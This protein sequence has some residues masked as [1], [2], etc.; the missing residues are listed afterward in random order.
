MHLPSS[1]TPHSATSHRLAALGLLLALSI[2]GG[3]TRGDYFVAANK[4]VTNLVD[5]KSHDPRWGLPGFNINM[6]PRSRFYDIYDHVRPPMPHDDPTAHQLMHYID[7]KR[8]WPFWAIDGSRKYLDNPYWRTALADYSDVNEEGE[9]HIDLDSALTVARVNNPDFQEQLETIYLSALDVSTERFRFD[10]QFFGGNLTRY[11][12][13]GRLRQ[14]GDADRV[15]PGE[16]NTLRTDTDFAVERR[17]ATAG[18]LAVNFANS[19]VWQFAGPDTEQAMSL[20]SFAVA[21]PLLRGAG[22]AVALEQLTLSERTL[23][24]NLRAFQRYRQGF[25]TDVAIGEEGVNGPQR[26]GGFF[27]GTGLTGFTGTGAGGFGGVGQNA[28]GRVGGNFGGGGGAAGAG[29][30]GGGAGEVGGFVGLL[31]KLQQIRN[32]QDGLRVRLEALQL[33]EAHLEAGTIDLQQV[34][35]FR[36]SI[37]TERATLL[38]AR[39]DLQTDMDSFKSGTLGLPPDTPLSLDDSLIRQF[40]FID[41][42]MSRLQNEIADFRE[43]FGE[44]NKA[45]VM[46][47]LASA[48]KRLNDLVKQ[49]RERLEGVGADLNDVTTNEE[50]IERADPTEAERL[51]QDLKRLQ[52]TY[53]ELQRR[54]A[55]VDGAIDELDQNLTQLPPAQVADSIATLATE[56]SLAVDEMTLVQARAR[57]EMVVVKPVDLNPAVAFSIARANRLDWMNNRAALVD[58]WRLIVFNANALRSDLNVFFTGDLQTNQDSP[59]RFRGPTGR[60]S[61]G[62]EF[63]GPFTRLLERNN[64]RQILIDYE[65]S[66]RQLIQY[67][68]GVYRTLRA[69]LRKLNEHHQNLEIQRRAVAI[70]IRRVDQTRE[71]LNQPPSPEEGGALGPTAALNLITALSDLRNAQD[72]FMSVWL[73]FLAA[74]MVLS[75]ELGLMQLDKRGIWI[76]FDAAIEV[77]GETTP[78]AEDIEEVPPPIP[79]ELFRALDIDNDEIGP[80]QPGIEPIA[81]PGNLPGNAPGIPPGEPANELPP[82]PLQFP[83]KP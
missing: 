29:F 1:P 43:E 12:H 32:R 55:Q 30:A 17:F 27:G 47:A 4:Q 6:N 81:P 77:Q 14:G 3:C 59:F 11:T 71:V 79:R 10:V 21:Q 46:T 16:N 51:V 62:V 61:V 66:R 2:V 23:L 13:L 22:R 20:L 63:D 7:H 80:L 15:K 56:I 68:D 37:E 44:L 48:T 75:R 60:L 72:N 36:Q 40:Q 26:R 33:L 69:V 31:Q 5:E 34:D 54:M 19:F 38:Q 74:R 45:P 58:T 78:K 39:N 65:Q 76:D 18:E 67:Q 9:L 83:A 57:L 50:A 28:F 8:G 82:P 35:Q 42:S 73:N 25:Y 24:A 52:E 70:A 64:F 49:T 41:P 53:A